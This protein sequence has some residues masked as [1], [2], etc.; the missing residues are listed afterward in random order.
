MRQ[1]AQIQSTSINIA[2]SKYFSE[3]CHI[4]PIHW[5]GTSANVPTFCGF[6]LEKLKF[7]KQGSLIRAGGVGNFFE[8]K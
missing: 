2:A 1:P 6:L 7:D 3:S 4:N 5:L 8:G